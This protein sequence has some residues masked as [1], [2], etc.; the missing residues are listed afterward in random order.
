MKL[1]KINRILKFDESNWLASYI[2]LNTNL[3]KKA[4]NDFEKGIFFLNIIKKLGLRFINSRS[5]FEW[6]C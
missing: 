4:K 2:D 3:R 5:N 6:F 1:K